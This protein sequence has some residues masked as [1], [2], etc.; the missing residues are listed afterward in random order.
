MKKIFS[1]TILI[2]ALCVTACG[3]EKTSPTADINL[4][5]KAFL[6]GDEVSLK[7]IGMTPEDYEK[8]FV[9]DF[10]KSFTES[11]GIQFT[12]E[13]IAK[14]NDAVRK[15]LASTT[16]ET[17]PVTEN[18]N[19]ATVKITVSTLSPFDENS[20][21]AKL[22]E[23]ITALSDAEINDAIINALVSLI[24]EWQFTGTVDFNVECAYN[25]TAKMWLPVNLEN[26]GNML[27]I[28]IFNVQ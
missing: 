6:Q 3:T 26:F 2:L 23:N 12:P 8:Q 25:D 9:E 5:C 17:A 7:K 1:L 28:K 4:L 24:Q 14:V 27:G 10:S 13:Q 21:R 16:F 19:N 15:L 20:L 18:D 11:S 22:P